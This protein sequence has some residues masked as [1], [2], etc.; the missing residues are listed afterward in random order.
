MLQRK[1]QTKTKKK[2]C[3]R[4]KPKSDNKVTY[5]AACFGLLREPKNMCFFKEKKKKQVKIKTEDISFC[6]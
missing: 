1:F 4:H 3:A 5:M 2:V 6:Q